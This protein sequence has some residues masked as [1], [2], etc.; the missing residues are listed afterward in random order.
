MRALS[1]DIA[2][3]VGTDNYELGTVD[4]RAD[5]LLFYGIKQVEY[6][7]NKD[8]PY[9]TFTKTEHVLAEIEKMIKEGDRGILLVR[10]MHKIDVT[11]NLLRKANVEYEM[12]NLPH[13]RALLLL[14]LQS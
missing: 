7:T 8:D 11:C 3:V 9:P 4:D 14:Q 13:R 6:L 1:E 5:G 12:I 10:G 2:Q